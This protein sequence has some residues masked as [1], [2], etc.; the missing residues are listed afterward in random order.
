M[1]LSSIA[2]VQFF[3]CENKSAI[4]QGY[5]LWAFQFI[6]CFHKKDN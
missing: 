5:L 1:V 2:I 3:T 4:I 6:V